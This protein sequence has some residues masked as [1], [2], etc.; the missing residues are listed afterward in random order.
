[1]LVVVEIHSSRLGQLNNSSFLIR[2]S[3][4]NWR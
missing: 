3:R 1:M 4:S 2:W